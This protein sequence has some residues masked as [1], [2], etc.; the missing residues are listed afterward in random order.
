M[1]DR[2]HSKMRA[3]CQR[4]C[5]SIEQGRPTNWTKTTN[6]NGESS[7][8]GRST[9]QGFTTHTH[10]NN[11]LLSTSSHLYA[12]ASE[13]R[14][15][16]ECR[17]GERDVDLCVWKRTHQIPAKK[18]DEVPITCCQTRE[19]HRSTYKFTTLDGSASPSSDVRLSGSS[20]SGLTGPSMVA[21]SMSS[22]S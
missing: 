11:N 21:P 7:C 12:H 6:R 19:C 2:H 16:G 14:H 3:R 4:T 13:R 5:S 20:C 15:L 17:H 18:F 1:S 10:N 8:E 22:F 9:Q